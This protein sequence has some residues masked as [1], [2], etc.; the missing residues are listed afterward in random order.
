MVICCKSTKGPM[1][2]KFYIVKRGMVPVAKSVYNWIQFYNNI[3]TLN[4]IVNIMLTFKK[5]SLSKYL[6]NL[7][8]NMYT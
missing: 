8:N 1:S 4:V 3:I 5:L 6:C 2:V 7:N